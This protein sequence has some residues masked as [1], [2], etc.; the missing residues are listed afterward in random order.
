[1]EAVSVNSEVVV[2]PDNMNEMLRAVQNF[3]QHADEPQIFT[4]V[5]KCSDAEAY[6]AQ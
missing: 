2:E 6:G 5:S 4:I 3:C 1:M